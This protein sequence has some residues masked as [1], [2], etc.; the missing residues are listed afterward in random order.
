M[1]EFIILNNKEKV[2]LFLR[3]KENKHLSLN[4]L[5]KLL[6]IS[7]TSLFNYYSRNWPIPLELFKKLKKY[8]KIK[9]IKTKKINKTRFLK[10]NP[11]IPIL[12]KFLSEILGILNGD[13]HISKYKYEINVVSDSRDIEYNEYIKDLFEKTFEIPMSS[14][15]LKGNAIKLR[16]YSIDLHKEL[17]LKY[18]LPIGK[19]K[20]NLK[21]PKAILSSRDFLIPYLRGLF[22]TDGSFYLRRDFEP[23]IQ[24]TSADIVFLNEIR[25]VLINLGFRVSKGNQRIFIYNKEDIKKFFN[26]IKPSNSKHLKKYQNYLNL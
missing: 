15:K 11:T 22:D 5:P 23:V 26:L 9:N 18:N 13:G 24:F 8:S 19:K 2:K 16:I 20:G 21:I 1:S 6:G 17:T 4:K 14:I 7:R 10:N 25:S 12:D 3:T